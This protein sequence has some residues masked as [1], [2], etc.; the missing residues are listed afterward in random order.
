MR[1]QSLSEKIPIDETIKAIE[2]IKDERNVE[3]L[4]A[5]V[6]EIMTYGKTTSIKYRNK[7]IQRFVELDGNEVIYSPLI[8][9]IN[10]IESYQTKKEVI[11]YIVCI[12]SDAVG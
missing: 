3:N 4:K 7:F 1:I 8:K 6:E 2:Y 5:Y 9:F 11:Y 10:D 12:T